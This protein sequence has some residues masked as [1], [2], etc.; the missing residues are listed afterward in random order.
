MQLKIEV[1]DNDG[2]LEYK[3]VTLEKV[4]SPK[5]SPYVETAQSILIATGDLPAKNDKDRPNND[6]RFG[7]TME[8]AVKKFQEK[9]KLK[10]TGRIDPETARKLDEA[11]DK[12]KKI[13]EV[14]QEDEIKDYV[15]PDG[16]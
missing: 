1:R 16:K 5:Y 2:T 10:P 4:D 9:V 13:K 14:K 3:E 11:F 6:G 8:E 15:T 12:L 7:K